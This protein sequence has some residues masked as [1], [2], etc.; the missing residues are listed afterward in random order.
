VLNGIS[1]VSTHYNYG[2]LLCNRET[3]NYW[4]RSTGEKNTACYNSYTTIIT[5]P[6]VDNTYQTRKYLWTC[7]VITH[8]RKIPHV[9][10]C[11]YLL[12][13]KIHM[14]MCIHV[15]IFYFPKAIWKLPFISYGFFHLTLCMVVRS[16]AGQTKLTLTTLCPHPLV[17]YSPPWPMDRAVQQSTG[18][19]PMD[20]PAQL[21]P[22]ELDSPFSSFSGTLLCWLLL[23]L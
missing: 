4:T 2:L 1:C 14:K 21:V 22:C 5:I 9:Y 20:E 10:T 6:M 7:L 11:G 23:F 17:P 18:R 16:I 12:F 19:W 8:L 3:S 13:S 15:G